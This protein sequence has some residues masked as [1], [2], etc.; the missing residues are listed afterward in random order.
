MRTRAQH[1]RS[2]ARPGRFFGD[3]LEVGDL[4]FCDRLDQPIVFRAMNR[5]RP[6]EIVIQLDAARREIA[7]AAAPELT[8]GAA[9]L[10]GERGEIVA[11]RSSIPEPFS[12]N[13]PL[14]GR[15]ASDLAPPAL[16]DLMGRLWEHSRRHRTAATAEIVLSLDPSTPEA[17]I[18]LSVRVAPHPRE[19][20]VSVV[21]VRD[22]SREK[23]RVDALLDQI[24]A[25]KAQKE[26]WQTVAR[27]V[28]H[29]VRSSLAALNGFIQLAMTRSGA[30]P[31][32]VSEHLNRALGVCTRLRALTEAVVRSENEEAPAPARTDLGPL[33]QRL[34]GALQAAHPDVRFT[35][36]VETAEQAAGLP[37]AVLWDAIWNLLDNSVKYRSPSRALHI[38]L[39]AW[40]EGQEVWIEVRD[41]GR[42]LVPGEEDAV[43]SP[44][45]R[46]SNAA[47]QEGSGLGL[48]S[49]RWLIE[50]WGGRAWA[51]PRRLGTCFRIA[52]PLP[53]AGATHPLTEET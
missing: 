48:S 32:A 52:V 42:G 12:R 16:G 19:R 13:S 20:T 1:P 2:K 36:C 34:L 15:K 25:L 11:H 24:D 22:L 47:D 28:A 9:M 14:S 21:T 27:T 51:E 39:R 43:F 49:V 35:W 17:Q 33:G 30:I 29:D 6:G 37:E 44:N 5:N 53:A 3:S 45:R 50:K 46:G 38:E 4:R 10:L 7:P 40:G 8:N 41:N 26:E 31:D 18:H 23:A